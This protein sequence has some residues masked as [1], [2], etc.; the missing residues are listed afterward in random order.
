MEPTAHS[1]RGRAAPRAFLLFSFVPHRRSSREADGDGGNSASP[2][3][4]AKF[5]GISSVRVGDAE[6]LWDAQEH[7]R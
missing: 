3:V 4:I 7:D 6:E 2:K 1:A 5:F